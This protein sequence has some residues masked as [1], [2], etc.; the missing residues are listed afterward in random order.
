MSYSAELIAVGTELLLGN[1]ANTDAQ[2]ISEGLAEL[3]IGV[4]FHTVVGDND[5]RLREVIGIAKKRADIIITTGGLGPTVDDM[6]KQTV[7]DCFGKKLVMDEA[8]LA[9]IKK[10]FDGRGMEMTPNNARQA[11][12]PEGCTILQN[13]WGTAPGVA[14]ESEGTTVIMLPGPPR[15]CRPMFFERA[16][17]YLKK[18]VDGTIVSHTLRIFGM[19]ESNVEHRLHDMMENGTNPT[20]APYAKEGECMLRITAK[21]TNEFEANEMIRPVIAEIRSI[22]G[23]VIYGEDVENLEEVVLKLA[24]RNFVTIAAAESCTGGM[25][26]ER[27]T[28]LPGASDVLKGGYCAY[29]NEFKNEIVGVPQEILDE[30]GAVSPEVARILAKR[31]A[32]NA[33]ANIGIGITGFA[34]PGGGTPEH[35]V[36]TVYVSLWC[37]GMSW[38]KHLSGGRDRNRIRRDATNT[39]FDMIRKYIQHYFR[40]ENEYGNL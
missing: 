13:A 40:E 35:P 22:L 38:V 23:N 14:F 2:M 18:F 17:P 4:Y 11:M 28:A 8:S 27:L 29:T 32:E 3:G 24:K 1:I 34:G 6:T 39:A 12:L 20:I 36:G 26:T 21:A 7:A 37:D 25:F 33:G 10:Y 16:V 31:A 15:E 30:K 5:S 19:G 9:E